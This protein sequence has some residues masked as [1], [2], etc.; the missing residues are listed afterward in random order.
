MTSKALEEDLQAIYVPLLKGLMGARI[1]I[2][3]QDEHH[4]FTPSM[5]L[6]ELKAMSAGQGYDW[7]DS[8]ILRANGFDVIEG[9]AFSLLLMLEKKRFDYF[10]RAIHEPWIEIEGNPSLTLN[11]IFC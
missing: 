2:I 1:A 6:S 8:D 10:P 5:T 11:L 4:I 3:R 7:P 9:S